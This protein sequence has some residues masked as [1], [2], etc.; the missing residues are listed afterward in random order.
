MTYTDYIIEIIKFAGVPA[1]ISV[2]ITAYTKNKYDSK[3]EELKKEYSK[4]ISQFQAELNYLKNKENFKFTKLHEKRVEVLQKAY[5]YLTKHLLSLSEYVIPYKKSPVG[6]SNYESEKILNDRYVELHNEFL[7]YFTPNAIFFDENL[8][9][10]LNNYFEETR[11]IFS[12][13]SKML[14]LESKDDNY[15][16]RI[17]ENAFRQYDKIP[18]IILPIKKEIEKKFRELLGE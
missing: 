8:E 5:G 18:E 14:D 15:K 17:T 1:L 9:R 16:D 2:S 6:L 4:E 3:L 12:V 11:K 13:Y 7:N 10:L